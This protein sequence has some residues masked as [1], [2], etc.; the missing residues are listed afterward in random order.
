MMLT[1]TK[2]I[3]LHSIKYGDTG[4]IAYV[5]TLHYGRL[6]LLV[7]GV[8]KKNAR[9]RLNNLQPLQV[10]D[11]DFYYK[12]KNEMHRL[13]ELKP[14][15]SQDSI[16]FDIN[17]T[18]VA[19]FVAEI[20]YKTLKEHVNNETLFY[21]LVKK[22]EELEL[23]KENLSL[24][25]IQFLFDFTLYLGFFPNSDNIETSAYFNMREGIFTRLKPGHEFYVTGELL[26]Y[27]RKMFYREDTI[28]EKERIP[29]F[30]RNELL[31]ILLDYYLLHID[32][33]GNLKSLSV[34][35]DV[36]HS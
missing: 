35:K 23:L 24:F 2:A 30:Y 28:A 1:K 7:Q 32:T 14:V 12:E 29:V 3:I 9:I 13:K 5:Y 8:R 16:L 25:H 4:V 33:F 6:S 27:F 15:L 36:F 34:L 22:I 19:L 20:L 21:F 10:L 18:T 11:I 26:D 17:K 31:N